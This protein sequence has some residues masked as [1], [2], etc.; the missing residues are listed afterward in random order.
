MVRL[1]RSNCKSA[2]SFVLLGIVSADKHTSILGN[3]FTER[4]FW[5]EIAVGRASKK[6]CS[7]IG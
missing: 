5:S 4:R 1:V 6:L 3:S 2:R 7:F